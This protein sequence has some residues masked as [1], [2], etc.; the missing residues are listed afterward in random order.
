[1]MC[2]PSL[3]LHIKNS[4]PD[5]WHLR[6]TPLTWLTDFLTSTP[7]SPDTPFTLAPY[8]QQIPFTLGVEKLAQL[9]FFLNIEC[10]SNRRHCASGTCHLTT[11]FP[12]S[13]STADTPT[14]DVT[15]DKRST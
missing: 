9:K 3:S 11:L 1:M 5:T 8:Q 14:P 6:S 7:P 15:N 2:S 4:A 10:I 12:L 13:K